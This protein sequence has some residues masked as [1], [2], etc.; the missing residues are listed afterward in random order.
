MIYA[1][2]DTISEALDYDLRT[3]RDFSYASMH[4]DD[5]GEHHT[6][7]NRE[8]HIDWNAMTEKDNEVQSAIQH[9]K[10]PDELSSK[11]K[12]CTLEEIAVLRIVQENLLATQK[13]IAAQIGKSERKVKS[14]TIA[15]Q[16]KG[17]MRR[18]N[19]KRNG[20]WEVRNE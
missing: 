8:L 10:T 9:A 14:I 5:V 15:L 18:V 6:L 4:V 13:D 2:H 1:S 20:H 7:R 11:C 3:E 17:I 19:G 16:K 12:S